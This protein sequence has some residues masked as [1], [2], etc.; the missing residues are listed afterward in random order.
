MERQG[1]E[2][3][4]SA[5]G[6]VDQAAL[7]GGRGVDAGGGRLAG[8]GAGM[9]SAGTL[10]PGGGTGVAAA[11]TLRSVSTTPSRTARSLA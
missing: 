4:P 2:K 11:Q 9:V 1:R 7:A 6:V 8:A 5:E 10:G 3:S